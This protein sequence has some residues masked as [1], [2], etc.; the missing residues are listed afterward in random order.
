MWARQLYNE[1][2]KYHLEGGQV[3]LPPNELLV[4]WTHGSHHVVE[5]HDNVDEGVEESEKCRMATRCESDTEPNAHR[6]DS[7]VDNV[8]Q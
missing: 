1:V 3:F 4:L 8:Q 6:H 5:V 7:V 2:L